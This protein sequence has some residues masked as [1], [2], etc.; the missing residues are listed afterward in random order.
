MWSGRIRLQL[1]HSELCLRSDQQYLNTLKVK[2]DYFSPTIS[3]NISTNI[4]VVFYLLSCQLVIFLLGWRRHSRL[5]SRRLAVVRAHSLLVLRVLLLL[6]NVDFLQPLE[7][8]QRCGWDVWMHPS[9][10]CKQI[11]LDWGIYTVPPQH[12]K[13]WRHLL[14]PRVDLVVLLLDPMQEGVIY[15]EEAVLIGSGLLLSHSDC[16]VDLGLSGRRWCFDPCWWL[17]RAMR[18]VE[19]LGIGLDD[20]KWGN[21]VYHLWVIFRKIA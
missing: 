14:N 7:V 6:P 17:L 16:F 12:L 10:Q 9:V 2:S 15:A 5:H 8:V 21:Q 11:I 1:P 4:R 20:Y 13:L 19:G 3:L 18:G